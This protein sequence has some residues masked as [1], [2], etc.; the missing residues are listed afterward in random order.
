MEKLLRAV[1]VVVRRM[2]SRG[3]TFLWNVLIVRRRRLVDGNVRRRLGNHFI[4]L[5]VMTRMRLRRSAMNEVV[6]TM[7]TIIVSFQIDRGSVTTV[8]SRVVTGAV[9]KMMAVG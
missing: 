2:A 6:M 9:M 4:H 1:H 5:V 7:M 3:R 8:D